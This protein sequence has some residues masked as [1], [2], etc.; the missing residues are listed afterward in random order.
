MSRAIPHRP[1]RPLGA[2][3]RAGVL[4]RP[5]LARWLPPVLLVLATLLALHGDDPWV[6][7]PIPAAVLALAAGGELVVTL[8]WP[9]SA[10]FVAVEKT[11]DRLLAERESPAPPVDQVASVAPGF[12]NR[13]GQ[14]RIAPRVDVLK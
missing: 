13:L 6:E 9:M 2:L 1:A 8:G 14:D 5:G 11:V 7:L 10:D 4:A 12:F 3:A